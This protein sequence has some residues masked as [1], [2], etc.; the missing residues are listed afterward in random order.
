MN[1]KI[2]NFIVQYIQE[3][4]Y[5]SSYREILDFTGLKSLASIHYYIHQL[6]NMRRIEIGENGA[7]RA[8]KVT[9]YKFVKG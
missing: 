4:G 6:V 3:N 8:I 5:A 1:N 9:G 7:S 2:Y